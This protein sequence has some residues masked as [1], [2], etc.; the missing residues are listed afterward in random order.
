MNMPWLAVQCRFYV[1]F[2][3]LRTKTQEVSM[4]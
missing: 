4:S 2:R 1:L 3:N